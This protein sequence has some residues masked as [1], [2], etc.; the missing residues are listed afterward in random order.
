MQN[1]KK[2]KEKSIK[3]AMLAPRWAVLKKLGVMLHHVGGKMAAKI[4]I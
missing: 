3:M 1:G 2:F 4:A